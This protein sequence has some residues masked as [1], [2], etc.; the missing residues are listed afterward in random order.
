[1]FYFFSLDRWIMFHILISFLQ[2]AFCLP[3]K[4]VIIATTATSVQVFIQGVLKFLRF[5]LWLFCAII[6]V[7]ESLDY[8]DPL[9]V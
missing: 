4:A 7:L 2:T 6:S 9:G 5:T 3:L 1:M 8:L